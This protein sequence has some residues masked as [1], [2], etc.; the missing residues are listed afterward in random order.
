MNK[1]GFTLVELLVAISILAILTLIAIPTLRAFQTRNSDSKYINYKKSLV[2]SGKL[3]NDSYSDDL[4]GEV[5]HG[6]QV[7]NL[8]ELL[9]K[10]L[11]KDISIKDVTCNVDEKNSYVVIKKFKDEYAYDA[12]LYCED[13]NHKKVYSDDD[14]LKST[15]TFDTES[16]KIGII[17]NKE[18]DKTLKKKSV[19]IYLSDIYGFTADQKIEYAWSTEENENNV[20]GYKAYDYNNNSIKTNG[21]DVI[22][23]SKSITMPQNADAKYYLYVKP[24]KVQNIL[25]NSITK[26]EKFGP[27]RFNSTAPE[28]EEIEITPNVNKK[29]PTKTLS[30]SFKYANSLDDLKSYTFELSYDNGEHWE[31]VKTD[32]DNN[33]KSYTVEKDGNIKYRLTNLLDVAGNKRAACGEVGTYIRD[34]KKPDCKFS[35]DGDLNASNYFNGS[36]TATISSTTDKLS[37]TS[38]GVASTNNKKYDNKDSLSFTKQG[39]HVAYGFVKDAAGNEGECISDKFTVANQYT[40]TFDGNGG[41]PS[42]DKKQVY[43]GAK[44]G[45]LPKATREGYTFLGWY[46][47]KDNQVTKNVIMPK[48]NIT[49]TAKWKIKNYTV[50]YVNN[51]R[52]SVLITVRNSNGDWVAR[53]LKSKD[54]YGYKIQYGSWTSCVAWNSGTYNTIDMSADRKSPSSNAGGYIDVTPDDVLYLF[55]CYSNENTWYESCKSSGPDYHTHWWFVVNKDVECTINSK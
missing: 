49:Y 51:T 48:K 55:S 15:C 29:T 52:G 2:T 12:N 4:F 22:L 1:R 45:T 10:N 31:K 40:I 25:F 21:S 18:E 16:P 7:V 13:S 24:I 30:F 54:S 37:D 41:T 23:K 17:S 32:A 6:C 53:T 8:K 27:F 42:T 36:A 14:V 26:V 5:N 11:A 47:N 50:K 19:I 3:Y 34:N 20:V 38:Y 9:L 35:I 46:D 28:C 44:I 43:W 33:F 39:E